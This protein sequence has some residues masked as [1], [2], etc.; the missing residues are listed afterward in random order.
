[1]PVLISFFPS[2]F[3]P[4]RCYLIIF[5]SFILP[6]TFSVISSTCVLTLFPCFFITLSLF[7]MSRERERFSLLIFLFSICHSL[8]SFFLFSFLVSICHSLSSFLCLSFSLLYVIL[9]LFS[10][11]YSSFSFVCLSPLFLNFSFS[12]LYVILFLFFISFSRYYMSFSLFISLYL[13]LVCMFSFSYFLFLFLVSICHSFS[14]FLYFSCSFLYVILSPLFFISFSRF[15]TSFSLLFSL[16]LFLVSICPSLSPFL[17]L[18]CIYS[19]FL[20]PV[21]YSSHQAKFSLSTK[22]LSYFFL[23][24]LQRWLPFSLVIYSY[25]YLS[26]FCRFAN[27]SDRKKHSHV[28]TSDKPYNCKVRGC[29]KSY[30]HP[31][32][33]RKHMKVHGKCSPPPGGS[34]DDSISN[35][36]SSDSNSASPTAQS[37]TPTQPQVPPQ[38]SPPSL[39]LAP[40]PTLPPNHHTNLSEWYVCQTT[41]GMPTPPSSEHSPVSKLG[42][43]PIHPTS[44]VSYT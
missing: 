33:L 22:H 1:M 9:S 13:F 15:Y 2:S 19:L 41:A 8:S 23:I 42:H 5:L 27:S 25:L 24:S 17:L 36:P 21:F 20:S 28:H 12:F 29:D 40:N 7:Y 14:S 44:V 26:F 35:S 34:Y 3:S 6:V 39:P 10:F 11:L 32:S 4:H 38:S 31:S 37:H 18:L 30:T 16:F 43:L